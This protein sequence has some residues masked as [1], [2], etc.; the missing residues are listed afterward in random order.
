MVRQ[1]KFVALGAGYQIRW[2]Q[3]MM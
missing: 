1:T 2:L 3:G